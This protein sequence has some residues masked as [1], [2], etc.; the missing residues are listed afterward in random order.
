MVDDY[1]LNLLDWCYTNVIAV[2]LNT[3]LYLWN[4]G[5]GDVNRLPIETDE[6]PITSVSWA[7]DGMF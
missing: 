7:G 2:A 6:V 4:A 3:S 1:Y 5:T